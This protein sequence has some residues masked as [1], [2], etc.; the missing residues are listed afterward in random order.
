MELRMTNENCNR[1]YDKNGNITR[2]SEYASYRIA[3]DDG[4]GVATAAVDINDHNGSVSITF[5][6]I[7]SIAEGE[8]KIRELFGIE[9]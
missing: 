8:A 2:R 3:D 7:D 1:D 6:G 5:E 4:E 9:G